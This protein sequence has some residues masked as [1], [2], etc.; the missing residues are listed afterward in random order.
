MKTGNFV[1]LEFVVKGFT[2][3]EQINAE[4]ISRLLVMDD[5][6]YIGMLGQAYTRQLTM[7]SFVKLCDKLNLE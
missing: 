4:H 3:V 1:D 2:Q 6:P 5:K 7:D